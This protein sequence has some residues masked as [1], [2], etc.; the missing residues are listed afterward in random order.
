MNTPIFDFVS[1][2]AAADPVRF[3]MPGH[4]GAGPLGCENLD[5]TEIQGADSLYEADGIIA[6]SERNAASLFGTRHTYYCAGGSSQ[7]LKAML[8]LAIQATGRKTI[9]AARN[10]HKAFVHAAALLDLSVQW[11]WPQPYQ[12]L[13][14]DVTPD[15]LEQALSQM[16]PPPAGVYLTSPDYLGHIQ[17]IAQ[18]A[19]VCHRHGVLLLVDNAHGAYLHFLPAPQ[20]PMDLG[21]DLCCDSAHKTLPVLTGGAYLHLAGD[22]GGDLAARQALA[23]FGSTSPS[24]L[25]LQS[26]DLCNRF[27]SQDARQQFA[28]TVTRATELKQQLSRQG[29]TVAKSEPLKIVVCSPSPEY[30]GTELARRV[31]QAGVEWEYADPDYLVLMASPGNR[32]EDFLRAARGLSQCP[33][34]AQ[35]TPVCTM[36]PPEP[37]MSIRQALLAPW[38]EVPLSQALGRICGAPTVSCP[39]AV[40][41]VVSGE[42]IS[43]DALAVLARY[44]IHF[45][46]VVKGST[47]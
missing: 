38:E 10:A 44:G 2:Y 14:C 35:P 7:C 1:R 23:L 29:W 47:L 15:M 20:H 24:Y 28:L 13:R 27:L 8:H 3:H 16:D 33:C 39:P 45:L 25:I 43:R 12:L 34:P 46:A 6:Q 4:K 30:P 42:R 37:A 36:G 32:E 21:A 22:F 9:L 17:P 26:L 11:L 19:E 41:V 31:K 5:I 40:P 18:L